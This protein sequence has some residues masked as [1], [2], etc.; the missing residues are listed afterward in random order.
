MSV[1][2]GTPNDDFKGWPLEYV[3]CIDTRRNAHKE[4]I[5]AVNQGRRSVNIE[6]FVWSHNS[7]G[8]DPVS[9][10]QDRAMSE[11]QLDA[12]LARSREISEQEY[13]EARKQIIEGPMAWLRDKHGP[14]TEVN[15]G[16]N[17][18][19]IGEGIECTHDHCVLLGR[20]L[21][22]TKDYEIRVGN[23]RIEASGNLTPEQIEA[24]LAFFR[25]PDEN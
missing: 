13:F 24:V 9:Y 10:R 16:R 1:F 21:K 22:S 19:L 18:V 7:W 8:L 2:G 12:F 11:E 17:N 5:D 23:E 15:K 20:G 14:E 6:S 25:A 4:H 3:W